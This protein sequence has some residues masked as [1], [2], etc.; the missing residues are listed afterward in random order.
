MRACSQVGVPEH[1]EAINNDPEQSMALTTSKNMMTS[2][3]GYIVRD[4]SKMASS[5]H[6]DY[7]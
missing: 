6:K 4:G 2:N 5:T 7:V 3:P 1:L